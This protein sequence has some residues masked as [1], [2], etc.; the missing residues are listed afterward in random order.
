[1]FTDGVCEQLRLIIQNFVPE[2][3]CYTQVT[4]IDEISKIK[5]NTLDESQT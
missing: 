2:A 3:Y 1:M 4:T 5:I